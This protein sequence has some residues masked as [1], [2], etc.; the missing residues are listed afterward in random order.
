MSERI[1]DMTPLDNTHAELLD[2]YNTAPSAGSRALNAKHL[3]DHLRSRGEYDAAEEWRQI[4]ESLWD[5][6]A[7]R[8]LNVST[9]D[10]G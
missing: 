8:Q 1:V 9:T 10:E 7:R 2:S 5:E 3:A 4:E 6:I